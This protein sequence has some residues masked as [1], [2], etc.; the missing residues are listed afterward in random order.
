MPPPKCDSEESDWN[1]NLY[2]HQYRAN[3]QSQVPIRQPPPGWSNWQKELASKIKSV[4]T[5]NNV[6]STNTESSSQGLCIIETVSISREA[7]DDL[8]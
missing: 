7:F 5:D 2:P 1:D 8:N 6:T 4:N 3:V